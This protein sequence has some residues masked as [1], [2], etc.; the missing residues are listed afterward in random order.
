ME[1]D[2]LSFASTK[3]TSGQVIDV[4]VVC[5]NEGGSIQ[6]EIKL[7]QKVIPYLN[8]DFQRTVYYQTANKTYPYFLRMKYSD[9]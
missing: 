8:I 7:I 6:K 9:I 1:G 2:V 4:C 3:I 5:S